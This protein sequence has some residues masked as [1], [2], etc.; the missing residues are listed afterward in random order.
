MFTC[1]EAPPVPVSQEAIFVARQ[2]SEAEYD[3]LRD[4][5]TTTFYWRHG[6][7][8]I[9][10]EL[11]TVAQECSVRGWD[12]YGADPASEASIKLARELICALPESKIR[13]SVGVEPDGQI[14]LEWYRAPRK[15]LSVSIDP[16]G[17]LH[18]AALIGDSESYG[19][20]PFYGDLSKVI[21]DLIGRVAE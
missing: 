18:Y 10:A 2:L 19:T 14:E 8:S 17:K 3:F 6:K 12:G 1:I 16:N 13:P 15:T 20:E 9:L 5:Y 21:V 4:G 7:L 11:N